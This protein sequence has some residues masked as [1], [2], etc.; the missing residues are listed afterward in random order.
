MPKAVSPRSLASIQ[1]GLQ[2]P[3]QTIANNTVTLAV[4]PNIFCD[5]SVVS[6]PLVPSLDTNGVANF[7][8]FTVP[9]ILQIASN[10]WSGFQ[11][12]LYPGL[13]PKNVDIDADGAQK[14]FV[15]VKG[16]L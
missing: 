7:I 2:I 15:T 13:S 10:T 14:T 6:C 4:N 9:P 16:D 3:V 1:S 8:Q 11:L 5:S 12:P